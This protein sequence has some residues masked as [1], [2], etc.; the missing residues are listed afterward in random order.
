MSRLADALGLTPSDLLAL[1]GEGE[2]VD[3]MS[4]LH[5]RSMSAMREA[6]VTMNA[7][8]P[9]WV[10]PL[11]AQRVVESPS[12][13]MRRVSPTRRD[14][15]LLDVLVGSEV[16]TADADEPIGP[17][18][19]RMYERA[20]SQVPVYRGKNLI[21]L[22]TND[23]VARWLGSMPGRS[24]RSAERT[25][26]AEVLGIAESGHPFELVSGDATVHETLAH[27]EQAMRE[28]R[29]LSAILVTRDAAASARPMGIVTA[30][31]L[32][33]LARFAR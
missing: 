24:R 15:R 31:D 29:P 17:V 21:G 22:L 7:W 25:T 23:A 9:E 5:V 16:M 4:A 12:Y 6:P 19:E 13:A 18:V 3:D 32:P 2:Q 11:R 28:G 20:Y 1:V 30:T 26:V 8:D 14:V 10:P 33:R 27:F